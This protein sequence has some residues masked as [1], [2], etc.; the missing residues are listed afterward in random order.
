MSLVLVDSSPRALSHWESLQAG[1]CLFLEKPGSLGQQ[2]MCGW[3][4]HVFFLAAVSYKEKYKLQP[5]N[6]MNS[7]G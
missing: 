3:K 2:H 4:N 7:D 1:L 6:Q 5:S